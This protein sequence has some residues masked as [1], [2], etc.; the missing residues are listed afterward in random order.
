MAVRWRKY[1][2]ACKGKRQDGDK[3][4]KVVSKGVDC[5]GKRGK[6]CPP[7]PAELSD[8]A[9]GGWSVAYREL[10][11]RWVEKVF[12][13]ITKTQATELYQEIQGNLRRNM[14]GLPNT[15]KI[16]TLAE[17]A[18]IYLEMYKGVKENTLAMKKRAVGVLVR[19]LGEYTLNQIT[20][21]IVE[22]FRMQRKEQDGVKDS[23]LNV[24]VAVLKHLLNTA[25][26]DE[27]IEKN[28]CEKIQRLKVSGGKDRILN[29]NE[30]SRILD[31]PESKDRLMI[32]TALFT[33][34]RLNEVLSL[35]WNDIDFGKGIVTVF[36]GK[37]GKSIEIP[38]SDYLR[39]ALEAYRTHSDGVRCFESREVTQAVVVR[40]SEYFSALFK[41]LGIHDFTFHCL[42]HTF[43]SIMGAELGVG[44]TV[45]MSMTGHSNL[46]TLQRYSH[47]QMENKR[48]AIDSLNRY[49]A[50]AGQKGVLSL[51]Q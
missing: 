48:I 49:V 28:P 47:S 1:H 32:L 37:T 8:Q 18:R 39:T 41:S 12:P 14:F 20:P 24:D 31:M 23:V 29:G 22:K 42:R 10:D 35:S 11:G 4:G 17:Y 5:Q 7:L 21:F 30:I 9:C 2:A 51:A 33:G 15:K 13:G 19:Y 40:Y 34:M 26:N 45:T 38:L 43:A 6:W 27:I 3:F 25:V 44:A 50:G 46:S 36:Q 16:P